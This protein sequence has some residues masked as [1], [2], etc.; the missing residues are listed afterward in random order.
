MA[1]SSSESSSSLQQL[2]QQLDQAVSSGHLQTVLTS[3]GLGSVLSVT[4]TVVLVNE[5]GQ[6]QTDLSQPDTPIFENSE[7]ESQI[8][9]SSNSTTI[10][11]ICVVS[12]AVIAVISA[13]IVYVKFYQKPSIIENQ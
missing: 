1:P 10:I 9:D 2:S 5:T 3:A 6:F 12:A 4:S 8:E 11:I 7:G 13:V